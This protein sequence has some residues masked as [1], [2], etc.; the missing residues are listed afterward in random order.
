MKYEGLFNNNISIHIYLSLDI[1]CSL[2]TMHQPRIDQPY[3]G[4]PEPSMP[5]NG[6]SLSLPHG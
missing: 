5:G 2:Q 4:F 1:I 3:P 6:M